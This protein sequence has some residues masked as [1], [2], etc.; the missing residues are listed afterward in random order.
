MAP[1]MRQASPVPASRGAGFGTMSLARAAAMSCASSTLRRRAAPVI[2]PSPSTAVS[3]TA[4]LRTLPLLQQGNVRYRNQRHEKARNQCERQALHE[5][6]VDRGCEPGPRVE[7]APK[8]G[9]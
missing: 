5:C 2:S 3:H 8:D 1:N 9:V 7:G 4:R 6:G